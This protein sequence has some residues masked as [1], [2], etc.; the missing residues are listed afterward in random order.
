MIGVTELDKYR[1]LL[2]NEGKL[3]K[4]VE[5]SD[6][7]N[8]LVH[9][10][11]ERLPEEMPPNTARMQV[12]YA[13]KE[14]SGKSRLFGQPFWILV[15][16]NESEEQL[17]SGVAKS[18]EWL[19]IQY[20]LVVTSSLL[21]PESQYSLADIYSAATH[22]KLLCVL[23]PADDKMVSQ[24]LRVIRSLSREIEIFN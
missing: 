18:V 17:R 24:M 15:Q 7:L 22:G 14:R 8:N 9:L 6:T 19:S 16:E 4:V 3:Q 12:V 2:M 21:Q 13:C 23:V 1:Y 10:H 11:I 20:D 5:P